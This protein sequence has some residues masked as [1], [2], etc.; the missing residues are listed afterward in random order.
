M[1]P[2]LAN[3]W[4]AGVKGADVVFC[5]GRLDPVDAAGPTLCSSTSSSQ[6]A[7]HDRQLCCRAEF[8]RSVICDVWTY[9]H[10]PNEPIASRG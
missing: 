9:D 6:L 10:E 5:N 3:E 2:R 7:S 8:S 4:I 1:G